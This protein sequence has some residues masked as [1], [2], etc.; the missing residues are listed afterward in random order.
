M[1]RYSIQ[2]S[3]FSEQSL[4]LEQNNVLPYMSQKERPKYKMP[5]DTSWNMNL[6]PL[7][8]QTTDSSIN[9]WPMLA[10]MRPIKTIIHFL[11]GIP[12]EPQSSVQVKNMAIGATLRTK[13]IASEL[14]MEQVSDHFSSPYRSLYLC[15]LIEQPELMVQLLP[16]SLFPSQS[17]YD[18]S[19]PLTPPPSKCLLSLAKLVMDI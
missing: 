1:M 11:I 12:Q 8:H 18:L 4:R 9:F 15:P 5:V 14:S 10:H 7:Q 17:L 19:P 3:F 16:L 6:A 2:V 13:S